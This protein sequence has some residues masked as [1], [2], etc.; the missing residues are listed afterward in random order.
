M[1][2]TTT[3]TTA[4][5]GQPPNEHDA[6]REPTSEERLY[7]AAPPAES[8]QFAF[9]LGAWECQG[10]NYLPDGST[11]EYRGLWHAELL[12]GGRMLFDTFKKLSPEGEEVWSAV[13]LRTYAPATGRWEM[14]TVTS[15]Q[16]QPIRSFVG[17][18][19]DGEMRMEIEAVGPEGKPVTARVR[20]CHIT[21]RSFEWQMEVPLEGNQWV[22]LKTILA[23]RRSSA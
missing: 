3:K 11:E 21:E 13:T 8:Q 15:L 16:P 6:T 7:L 17:R 19:Q 22:R 20:F 18:W 1:Q 5:T 10:Q 4:S 23:Q 14:A 12:F 9:L 2:Q